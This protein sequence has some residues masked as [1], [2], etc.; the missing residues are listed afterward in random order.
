MCV[1]LWQAVA[2]ELF[3]WN[4]WPRSLAER[5][6]K[7]QYPLLIT[8]RPKS[9]LHSGNPW[10]ASAWASWRSVWDV[11]SRAPSYDGCVHIGSTP[12]LLSHL[13][14]TMFQVLWPAVLLWSQ[15]LL[16]P[17]SSHCNPPSRPWL[18]E[19]STAK[20]GQCLNSAGG[21]CYVDCMVWS[22]TS[23]GRHELAI[24]SKCT[25]LQSWLLSQLLCFFLELILRDKHF[26]MPFAIVI[27]T[28]FFLSKLYSFVPATKINTHS[29]S[30]RDFSA[31]PSHE[32]KLMPFHAQ[33]LAFSLV[34]ILK[35]HTI[36]STALMKNFSFEVQ[37]KFY[38]GTNFL[39]CLH[40]LSA[41][42]CNNRRSLSRQTIC[43]STL[44][45]SAVT[46]LIS[47]ILLIL[48]LSA[49][50]SVLHTWLKIPGPPCR[51]SLW[52]VCFMSTS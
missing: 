34:S 51:L 25:W 47:S 41:A 43:P 49:V 18:S 40:C 23:H 45:C 15:L 35:T 22:S 19:Y 30:L 8:H 46:Y 12:P 38:D 42:N 7:H 32:T 5:A 28:F 31:L 27:W 10:K 26:H 29:L 16:L 37:S 39:H 14:K 3:S 13:W 20:S 33:T 1:S 24:E 52:S 44:H 36:S 9:A 17:C 11:F 21:F 2:V 4:R 50:D 48:T 6:G